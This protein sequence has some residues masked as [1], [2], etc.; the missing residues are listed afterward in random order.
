MALPPL[1]FADRQDIID[2]VVT[3][4]TSFPGSSAGFVFYSLAWI[5]REP[6]LMLCL[7]GL[8]VSCVPLSSV[9]SVVFAICGVF[10]PFFGFNR[11]KIS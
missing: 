6:R 9:S 5:S 11:F 4:S 10:C 2:G 8:C 3:T 7:C 1:R